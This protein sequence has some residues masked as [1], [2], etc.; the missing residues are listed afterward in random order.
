MGISFFPYAKF[1]LK[2]MSLIGQPYY[3][4]AEAVF[5]FAV[6]VYTLDMLRSLGQISQSKVRAVA[7]RINVGKILVSQFNYVLLVYFLRYNIMRISI[8]ML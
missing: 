7:G 1:D 5:N 3:S 4:G 6:N 2:T 8:L